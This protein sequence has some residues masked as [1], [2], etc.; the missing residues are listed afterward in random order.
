MGSLIASAQ[1]LYQNNSYV[2]IVKPTAIGTTFNV[3][4]A[5]TVTN[6]ALIVSNASP[7]VVN[8]YPGT[9]TRLI[10]VNCGN[11]GVGAITWT[12]YNST[13]VGTVA[14]PTGGVFVA[15]TNQDTYTR[16]W[17][18]VQTNVYLPFVCNREQG[19]VRGTFTAVAVTNGCVS[20]T[21]I[22]T[23]K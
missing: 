1:N 18:N 4:G 12:A 9:G 5:D 16:A 17:T 3:S 8:T 7:V 20:D 6:S 21:L 19:Y 14:S 11:S 10:S 23:T 15:S 13:N 22:T 2:T